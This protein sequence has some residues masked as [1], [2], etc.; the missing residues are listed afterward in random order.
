MKRKK[1]VAVIAVATL[2]GTFAHPTAG[3]V[4]APVATR[5]K[6]TGVGSAPVCRP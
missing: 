6:L 5:R 2:V 1:L 4:V 3:A